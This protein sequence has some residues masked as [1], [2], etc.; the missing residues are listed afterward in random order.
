MG[1]KDA[2]DMMGVH[3]EEPEVDVIGIPEDTAGTKAPLTTS[4]GGALPTNASTVS[5]RN[6]RFQAKVDNT[7]DKVQSKAQVGVLPEK[8][9][10]S[11]DIFIKA[12]LKEWDQDQSGT[13]S[14]EEVEVAM[15]ELRETMANLAKLKW[16]V[17]ICTVFLAVALFLGLGA[18]AIA[19]ALAKS[20]SVSGSGTMQQ[21]GTSNSVVTTVQSGVG[22]IPSVL[23]FDDV[24][25]N[26]VIDD[27]GLRDLDSVSFTATN[28]TFYHFKV[29]E[30]RRFDSGPQGSTDQ[31]DVVTD[32]GHQLRFVEMSDGFSSL[33]VKW[34]D[35]TQWVTMET[36]TARRLEEAMEEQSMDDDEDE[37]LPQ[38]GGAVEPPP[39]LLSKGHYVGGVFVHSR[40]GH[41]R[42][43]PAYIDGYHNPEYY[44]DGANRFGRFLWP[45]IV[46]FASLLGYWRWS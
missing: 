27:A 43:D 46:F 40:G 19:Y 25:D 29:A 7:I 11:V 23:S 42:C 31:L 10:P 38:S 17:I 12:K 41:Y 30:L 32:G 22:D 33:E 24:S 37:D 15:Q 20:T 26:W 21:K 4:S 6:K 5:F 18:A 16:Q 13:F 39:R 28:G 44:C 9:D 1:L 36:S 2:V 3:P 14:R 45:Q 8:A 34:K 35:T